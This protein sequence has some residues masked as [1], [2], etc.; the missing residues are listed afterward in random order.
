M[1]FNSNAS[2]L[3]INDA[4]TSFFLHGNTLLGLQQHKGKLLLYGRRTLIVLG[5]LP[6][7]I[8]FFL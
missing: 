4:I 5:L 6:I 8:N 2:T 3:L 7:F 1:F